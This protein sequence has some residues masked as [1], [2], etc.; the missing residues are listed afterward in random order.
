M[1]SALH[2]DATTTGTGPPQLFSPWD[3]Q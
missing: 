1:K 3:H 2:I